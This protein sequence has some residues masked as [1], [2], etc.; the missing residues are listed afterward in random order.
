M[1]KEQTERELTVTWAT[2]YLDPESG[3][4]CEIRIG[5]GDGATVLAK[6]KDVLAWLDRIGAQPVLSG[7]A[8]ASAQATSGAPMLPLAEGEQRLLITKVKR[9]GSRADLYAKGDRYPRTK[10]FDLGLLIPV[11][12][13]VDNLAEGV[14]IPC[15]FYAVVVVG[16][17]LNTKGNPY[18]NVIRA[19]RAQ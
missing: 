3:R 15:Y 16:E 5:N 17:K 10:L 1:E 19:E 9:D 11:G 2:R 14:E 12:L 8:V 4:E 7:Q 13:D 18:L 6:S